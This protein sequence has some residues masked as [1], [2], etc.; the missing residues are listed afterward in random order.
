MI[1]DTAEV[2]RRLL[3]GQMEIGFVG[4][5]RSDC[6]LEFEQFAVDRLVLVAPAGSP[7]AAKEELDLAQLQ[8]APFLLREAGS[9]TRMVFEERLAA[10]GLTVNNLTVVAELGST[11]AIKQGVRSGIGLSVLSEIAVQAEV[12]T[13]LMKRIEVPQLG[14]LERQFFS[15]VDGRRARSPLCLA[16][17]SFLA[18]RACQGS[19]R[20]LGVP[21]SA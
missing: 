19:S 2:L 20:T 21:V 18:S 8:E 10:V 17:Q 13:R 6:P 4:R 11:S 5:R 7:W 15:V 16:F 9:A 14:S 1:H 3:D 12:E